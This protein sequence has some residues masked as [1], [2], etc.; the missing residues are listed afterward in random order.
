MTRKVGDTVVRVRCDF[1]R[2][3]ND[4]AEIDQKEEYIEEASKGKLNF[5][6]QSIRLE[7]GYKGEDAFF[8]VRRVEFVCEI[9][10]DKEDSD[11]DLEGTT[12]EHNFGGG[13]VLIGET[14]NGEIKLN[15]V[16]PM[17][18]RFDLKNN[19]MANLEYYQKYKGA[20]VSMLDS[21]YVI[22]LYEYLYIHGF[23]N[24]AAR[25]L[26]ALGRIYMDK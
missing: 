5:V 7:K 3:A 13:L 16:L 8:D 25:C 12:R 4:D 21:N 14:I 11:S 26:E 1:G 22:S 9:Y 18:Q 10:G 20:E 24:R 15:N 23:D 6:E 17:S 2:L 19:H